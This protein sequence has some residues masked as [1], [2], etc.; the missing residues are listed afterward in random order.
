MRAVGGPNTGLPAVAICNLAITI[1]CNWA[2]FARWP[3]AVLFVIT[4]SLYV[5]VLSI[6]EVFVL[7]RILGPDDDVWWQLIVFNLTQFATVFATLLLLRSLGFELLRRT[8]E[9]PADTAGLPVK[10]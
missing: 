10:S 7:T 2:A 6:V 1:P 4:G 3:V 9:P 8:R 5:I